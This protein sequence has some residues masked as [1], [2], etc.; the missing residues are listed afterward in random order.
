MVKTIVIQQIEFNNSIFKIGDRVR[1]LLKNYNEYIG[2]VTEILPES[3]ALNVEDEKK[4][5]PVDTVAK[6]RIARADENF[7]N[8]WGFEDTGKEKYC[9]M[10]VKK[11]DSTVTVEVLSDVSV[12]KAQQ[13]C[14]EWGW[15]YDDGKAS[16][17]LNIEKIN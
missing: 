10:A 15:S 9:V 6:I 13:F 14:E 17:W 16:Y 3:F 7:Y 8:T 4:S 12:E 11:G 5:L 1:V 2:T